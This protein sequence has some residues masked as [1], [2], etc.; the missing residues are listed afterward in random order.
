MVKRV[1]LIE[2]TVPSEDNIADA[3]FRK[4]DKYSGLADACRLA[5]WDTH[6]WTIEVGVRGFVAG[7]LRKCLKWLDVPNPTI[8][9]TQSAASKTSLRCSYS[10]YLARNLPEWKPLELLTDGTAAK[11]AHVG[12]RDGTSRAMGCEPGLIV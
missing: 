2:L 12:H 1:I 3:A 9:H 6:V 11:T 7:S 5:T 10:I 8:S 4:K